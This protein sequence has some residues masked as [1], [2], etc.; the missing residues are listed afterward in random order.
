[1]ITWIPLAA[2]VGCFGAPD[3]APERPDTV[4]G[5][6]VEIRLTARDLQVDGQRVDSRENLEAD[7]VDGLHDPLLAAL[8]G[9]ENAWIQAPGDTPWMVVRKL[10]VTANEAGRTARWVS[11]DRAVAH[12]PSSKPAARFRPTC[13]DE[14]FTVEGISR[15]VSIELFTGSDGSWVEASVHF[16][17]TVQGS[18]ALSLPESCWRGASCALAGA[19]E[20]SCEAARSGPEAPGRVPIAGPIGCMLPIR[21]KAG[22]EAEWPK[23]LAENLGE[24]AI[25]DADEATLVIEA[26]TPWSVVI[27]VMDGFAQAD[28]P[29][30]AL[31]MPLVEGH[32]RPPLCTA[33]VRDAATLRTAGAKWL[34]SRLGPPEPATEP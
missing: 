1:M 15:R 32:G 6:A 20:P 25:T 24:L 27:A 7:L 16:A 2:L 21:K 18:A 11:G 22:D 17:P 5:D 33:T 19:Q 4:P 26:N 31:G 12:G 13:P 28:L 10:I 23:I 29:A 14:G 8:D 34:G 3:D 9:G 30:P